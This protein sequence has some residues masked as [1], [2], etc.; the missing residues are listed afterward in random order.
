MKADLSKLPETHYPGTTHITFGP[1]VDYLVALK[2]ENSYKFLSDYKTYV[3]EALNID[4]LVNYT[5]EIWKTGDK[6]PVFVIIELDSSNLIPNPIYY[7]D[8][9]HWRRIQNVRTDIS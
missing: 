5:K 9:N 4:P 1:Q 7:W 6:N 2:E 8:I 3:M